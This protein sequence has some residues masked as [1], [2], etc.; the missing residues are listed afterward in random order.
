MIIDDLDYMEKEVEASEIEGGRRRRRRSNSIDL[1]SLF[2]TLSQSL[3]IYPASNASNLNVG[4][5]SIGNTAISFNIS[6]PILIAV[7]GNGNVIGI[8]TPIKNFF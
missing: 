5:N 8:S 3:A 4:G 6:M 1:A 2:T 7:N